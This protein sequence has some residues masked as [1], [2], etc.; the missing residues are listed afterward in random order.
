MRILDSFGTEAEFNYA[1]YAGLDEK[2][3]SDWANED[4]YLQQIM[5]MFRKKK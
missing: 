5:T 3:R 2:S 1:E 4:V